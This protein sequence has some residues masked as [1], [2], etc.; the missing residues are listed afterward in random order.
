MSAAN[1]RIARIPGDG[2]GPEV[3]GEASK[4]LERAAEKRGFSITWADYPFGADHYLKTGEILPDSAVDEMAEMDALFLGAVGDPRVKP[5]ILERG[6][7]LHLRFHFDQYVNLRPAKSYPRV[8]LPV[9]PG[10]KGLNTLVVRENTEDFYMGIG[11]RTEKGEADFSLEAKRGLYSLDGRLKGSFSGG[12]EGVFQVGVASEPAIRR[13]I[14]YGCRAARARGEDKITLASKS[15]ALP[16]IYGFWEDVARDEAARQGAGLDI[17]N[18]DAMCYHLVR[19]PDLYGVVVAPNLFGDIISDLLAGLA[20][21]LGVAAGADIGDGL[22]MFEPIHGSAPAI[23]GTGKANPMAA[24]LTGALL[25]EHI[26]EKEAADD[27]E[28]A[29]EAFLSGASSEELPAEFGGGGT[30][31]SVGAE[32]LKRI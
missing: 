8:P 11:G 1:Y 15:N 32:I 31:S 29:L 24:I 17:V 4:I 5:G 21:G 6:I 9:A 28:K 23:A 19:T 18:A 2:I 16:Q 22:S 20:G 26:G 14:A 25:L 7:L 3:I 27:V 10:P 12:T 30:V 13:V